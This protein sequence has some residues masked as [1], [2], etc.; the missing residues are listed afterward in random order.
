MAK[1]ATEL[2]VTQP[3]VSRAIQQ[4]EEHFGVL[5]LIRASSGIVPTAAGSEIFTRC[6]NILREIDEMG[7]ALKSSKKDSSRKFTVIYQ[8]PQVLTLVSPLIKRFAAEVGD[9]EVSVEL[10]PDSARIHELLRNLQPSIAIAEFESSRQPDMKYDELVSV[11]RRIAVPDAHRLANAVD[12]RIEDFAGEICLCRTGDVHPGVGDGLKR[13]CSSA[14]LLLEPID[15]PSDIEDLVGRVSLGLG[16]AIVPSFF[17]HRSRGVKYL[18]LRFSPQLGVELCALRSP[19]SNLVREFARLAKEQ[20]TAL[21]ED[22]NRDP[23]VNK[24]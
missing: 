3:A 5:L 22:A 23:M 2:G 4:L 10:E 15:P 20:K 24:H 17:T 6:Q 21:Q 12:V 8:S 13:L 16:V 14:G 7:S 18:S 19:E 11:P 9:V 1:A